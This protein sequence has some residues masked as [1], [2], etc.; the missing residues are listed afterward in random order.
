MARR[1]SS[2]GSAPNEDRSG[3]EGRCS[4]GGFHRG[5]SS[6]CRCGADQAGSGPGAEG[7]LEEWGSYLSERQWGTVREDYSKDGN[8]WD[9]FKHDDAR[10]R[11]SRWGEDG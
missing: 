9:Y 8:A 1:A 10:P 2:D 4:S 5:N 11:A 3:F 7:E 6:A